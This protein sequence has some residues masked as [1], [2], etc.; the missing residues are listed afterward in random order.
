MTPEST[1]PRPPAA[2]LTV[3]KNTPLAAELN[4]GGKV[5][6][7]YNTSSTCCRSR[8]HHPASSSSRSRS[9]SRRI[10]GPRHRWERRRGRQ[11]P[12]LRGDP[13]RSSLKFS[14]ETDAASGTKPPSFP[15]GR[16]WSEQSRVCRPFRDCSACHVI[17][18]RLVLDISTCIPGTWYILTSYDATAVAA[19]TPSAQSQT[20]W[21]F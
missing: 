20:C 2:S 6:F 10:D 18:A 8:G 15:R 7:Q 1:P 17:H 3:G 13:R 16:C 21:F 12:E 19:D 4:H 14:R 5:L 11:A 9:R